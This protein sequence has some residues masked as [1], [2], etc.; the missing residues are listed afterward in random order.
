MK[1]QKRAGMVKTPRTGLNKRTRKR[2]EEEEGENWTEDK[3]G[4]KRG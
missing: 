3:G 4:E 1:E 2:E